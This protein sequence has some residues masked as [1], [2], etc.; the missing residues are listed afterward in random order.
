MNK[1]QLFAA[2]LLLTFKLISSIS[3]KVGEANSIELISKQLITCNKT[4]SYDYEI[5][6]TFT[7]YLNEGNDPQS[8]SNLDKLASILRLIE[9]QLLY[10]K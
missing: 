6:Q 2:L 7:R 3:D 9:K 1:I 8:L 10:L 4:K 5:Y